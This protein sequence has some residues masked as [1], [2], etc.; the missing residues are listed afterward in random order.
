MK[1]FFECEI[2]G[3]TYKV[4]LLA[5]SSKGE[6]Q[7]G[8]VRRI[9]PTNDASGARFI[10][11]AAPALVD[12][13]SDARFTWKLKKDNTFQVFV[14]HCKMSFLSEYYALESEI[15]RA[16]ILQ[17]THDLIAGQ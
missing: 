7:Y 8:T 3:N 1:N 11:E 10:W 15:N 16:Y 2:L 9:K 13:T 4:V 17:V 6:Q 14:S 5:P 12:D